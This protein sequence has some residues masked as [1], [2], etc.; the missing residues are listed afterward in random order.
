MAQ[1]AADAGAKAASIELQAGAILEV[2]LFEPGTISRCKRQLQ[3]RVHVLLRGRV[4]TQ[5]DPQRADI[6][7]ERILDGPARRIVRINPRC[8]ARELARGE[9]TKVNTHRSSLDRT[10]Q[11]RRLVRTR[12]RDWKFSTFFP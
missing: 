4:P 12:P 10:D 1:V 3:D 6:P 5:P 8:A 7:R 2:C 11:K 9:L